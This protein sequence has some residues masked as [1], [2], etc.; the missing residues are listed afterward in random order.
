MA[1]KLNVLKA[2]IKAVSSTH[3]ITKTMDMIA[4]SRTAKIL[5]LEQGMRPFTQK[6]NRIVEDLSHSDMDHVH[7]LLA[8]K[9][10]LINI[11]KKREKKWKK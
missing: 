6:L 1:E 9:K 11:I 3:K 10:K 8:P 2:R 4:R 5:T 7:P